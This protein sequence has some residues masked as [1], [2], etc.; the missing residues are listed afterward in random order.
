MKE[1]DI[2]KALQWI[3]Q[4]FTQPLKTPQKTVVFVTPE[5][6]L[7]IHKDQIECMGCLSAC[8]FSNWDQA[9][10]S[11]GLRPDPRSFCIQKTLQD[12]IHNGSIEDNLMFAGHNVFMFGQDP[13]CANGF[14]PTVQELV[15][16]ICT[17]D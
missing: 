10:G 3:E 15:E 9:H 8:A 12:I 5:K 11:T 13:F 2:H 6:A 16:R 17:G 14:I 1:E 4:G 7:S